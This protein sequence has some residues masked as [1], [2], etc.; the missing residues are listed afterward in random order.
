[1][2]IEPGDR[3]GGPS[4]RA[5]SE[6]TQPLLAPVG[7]PSEERHGKARARLAGAAARLLPCRDLASAGAELLSILVEATGASRASLMVTDPAS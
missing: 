4:D 6:G 2:P 1:M 7:A 3:L 5:G